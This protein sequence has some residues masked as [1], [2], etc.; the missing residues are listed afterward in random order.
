MQTFEI[1][2]LAQACEEMSE[3]TALGTQQN[4]PEIT[5]HH[6][7]M[8]AGDGSGAIVCAHDTAN[9]TSQTYSIPTEFL[10]GSNGEFESEE[11]QD[12]FARI[13]DHLTRL[14]RAVYN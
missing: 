12:C 14:A 11:T 9:G 8:I 7:L 6:P 10:T 13:N 2:D 1:I 3:L 5:E 4:L